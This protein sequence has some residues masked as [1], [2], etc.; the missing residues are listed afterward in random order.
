MTLRNKIFPLLCV[1]F[2]LGLAPLKAQDASP[3]PFFDPQQYVGDDADGN[4]TYYLSYFQ[5]FTYDAG[6]DLYVYKYNFGFL[7]YFGGTSS[8]DDDAYFYDFTADDYFYTAPDL[9]PYIYSFN[10]D[11]YLYYF[12]DSSPREF[13]DFAT[14]EYLYY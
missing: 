7:Y 5:Y 4:P 2:A 12:E 6:D 9:Y 10:L 1:L 8:T 13:Y 3:G 11:T 14:D